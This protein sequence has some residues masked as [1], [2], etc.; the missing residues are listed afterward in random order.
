M[1]SVFFNFIKEASFCDPQRCVQLETAQQNSRNNENQETK[2][3]QPEF[4][5]QPQATPPVALYT[6]YLQNQREG[7]RNMQVHPSS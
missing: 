6:E 3:V 2:S 7:K 4:I 1:G 5:I